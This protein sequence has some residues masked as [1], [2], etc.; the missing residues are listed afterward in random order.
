MSCLDKER[1]RQLTNPTGIHKTLFD[2]FRL[3]KGLNKRHKKRAELRRNPNVY[4]VLEC[5]CSV[6]SQYV[7][8]SY[9]GLLLAPL[10][11]LINPPT[12]QRNRKQT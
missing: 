9:C 4:K 1:R 3:N 8:S 7:P 10:H 12:P 5:Q 11:I 2:G 6:N